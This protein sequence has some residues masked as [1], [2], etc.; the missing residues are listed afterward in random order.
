VPV[1]YEFAVS[2]PDSTKKYPVGFY[3]DSENV[4]EFHKNKYFHGEIEN[5]LTDQLQTWLYWLSLVAADSSLL[6]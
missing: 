1:I 3:S 5:N 2:P 4:W 6:A